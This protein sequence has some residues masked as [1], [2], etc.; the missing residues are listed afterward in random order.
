MRLRHLHGAIVV[1]IALLIGVPAHAQDGPDAFKVD[2]LNEG[3][4]QPDALL[5]RSTPKATLEAFLSAVG[6]TDY[7]SAAHLLDLAAVPVDAQATLGPQL[8][9][10]LAQIIERKI[11]I[12]YALVVDRP[13]GM[14]AVGSNREPM[15]G[16]TR[17]SL[18]LGTLELTPWPVSIRLNRVAV[19]DQDPVWVFSR[20]TV[21]HV[22]ALY[23]RYGPT[24]FEL[25]LPEPLRY[26]AFWGLEWWEV[27]AIPLILAIA[28][29]I[30]VLLWRVLGVLA[31]ATGEDHI[32]VAIRRARLP[33]VL[34]VLAVFLKSVVGTLFEFSAGADTT[35]S[36]LFWTLIVL[37][38][39][40][41]VA[42]ALDTVIDFTSNRYL[43]TIDD[44]ENTDARRWYTNL[45][46]V[47]RVG[48]I[49][50]IVVGV[51]VALSSLKLFDSFG[52]S[53]LVSAGVATAVFGLAAQTVLGNIFASL[54]LAF[55]KPIRI[56]DAVYY[57]DT[58]AYVEQI[59]YTYVQL[60]TWDQK[61]FIVP[62]QHFVSHPFE[63]WTKSDPEMI[64]PVVLKL[65]HRADVEML[66]RA[67]R[68]LANSDPDWTEGAEPKVQVVGQDEDGIDVRFYCTADDPTSAWNLH[69][70]VRE[71][72]VSLL[73]E[74]DEPSD[75]PRT[76]VAYVQNTLD[77]DV[78][79]PRT[80]LG[81]ADLKTGE[82]EQK[83]LP[84]REAAE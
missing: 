30:G 78:G 5:D 63:N 21:E 9:D 51:A 14:D 60:R 71:R 26:E 69:C 48:V 72:M 10:K 79:A 35:I 52:L 43:E 56:G 37:A 58:W 15:V 38:L 55:A 29:A 32:T 27:I 75:L 1:A 28:A 3:L 84:G 50:V 6:R 16:Q 53:L 62:V 82:P 44:P 81:D 7:E 31:R 65:D 67:F 41:G 11:P 64:M 76:R 17:R 61:R 68:D 49:A 33:A 34:L 77:E 39:V 42:R 45:S 24:D 73:R 66:R 22:D 4:P 47:K 18:S 59:N 70:R 13:D 74:L 8:A 20:Q 83:P 80:D 36:A 25:A 40:F 12:D 2:A 19:G 57:D 54:Q 46:A 23:A